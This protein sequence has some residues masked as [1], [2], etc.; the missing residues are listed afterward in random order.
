[1]NDSLFEGEA[2]L[3][4]MVAAGVRAGLTKRVPVV[5]RLGPLALGVAFLYALPALWDSVRVAI[6]LASMSVWEWRSW[7]AISR[8]IFTPALLATGWPLALAIFLT[9][10]GWPEV[11]W[12]A[13]I[14]F[15]AIAISDAC[16]IGFAI[17][18]QIEH[19]ALV[20]FSEKQL[21]DFDA[22]Y[23]ALC[24]I[25]SL[26]FVVAL[27]R[28]HLTQRR[29]AGTRRAPTS[30]PEA[31][32]GRLAIVCSLIFA[33]FVLGI[34][35][36]VVYEKIG[37]RVMA[38][39]TLMASPDRSPGRRS[40]NRG[41]RTARQLEADNAFAAIRSARGLV[42]MGEFGE[43][44]G[45]YVKGLSEMERIARERNDSELFAEERALGFNNLAWLLATCPDDSQRD[46]RNAIKF[47]ERSLELVEQDGNSWNTLGVAYYR[48]RELP[49][50]KTALE[51]SMSLRN[52]GDA[53]D[54]FFLAMIEHE[55]GRSGLAKAWFDKAASYRA[56]RAGDDIELY[57]FHAEA[58]RLLGHSA[59]KAPEPR[60][61]FNPDGRATLLPGER[62]ERVF[63]H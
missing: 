59:P 30:R 52:G 55:L 10:S 37:L 63:D 43:A 21:R 6:D 13:L 54:W 45:L 39:R 40:L 53:H 16:R 7:S 27:W 33:L 60:E 32:C 41:R 61:P 31:I 2:E 11:L 17:G 24:A 4:P 57:R 44:R 34:Q 9:W 19:E 5:S 51:K 26:L 12:S 29:Q 36:W 20:F 28:L 56:E 35:S 38:I 58:A 50:A 23:H 8:D 14:T 18:G 25:V 49:E 15:T 3:L 62:V 1:M 46:A 48:A 47:A 22:C 42:R